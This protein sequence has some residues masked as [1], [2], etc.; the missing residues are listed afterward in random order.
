MKRG[1]NFFSSARDA[2]THPL[3]LFF[4]TPGTSGVILDKEKDGG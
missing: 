3:T 2:L 1:V 4:Q